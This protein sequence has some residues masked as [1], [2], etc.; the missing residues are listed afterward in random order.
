MD[1]IIML[2]TLA[3]DFPGE[4]ACGNFDFLFDIMVA[5]VS[6]HR[7]QIVLGYEHNL[8]SVTCYELDH[9]STTCYEL[10]RI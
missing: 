5:T 4:L 3:I 6:F 10:Y 8:I 9:I 7:S 2:V 1:E